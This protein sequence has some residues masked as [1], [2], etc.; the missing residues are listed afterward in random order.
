MSK[1]EIASI[2]ISALAL[3]ASGGVLLYTARTYAAAHRP[4][5]GIIS[6][7]F[8]LVEDP[9]RAIV[10]KVIIKNVGSL[11]GFLKMLENSACLT[12]ATLTYDLDSVPVATKQDRSLLMPGEI[13]ELPGQ[14]NDYGAPVQMADIL[15]G[16]A[17]IRITLRFSYTTVTRFWPARR[18]FNAEIHF[19]TVKGFEPGFHIMSV[20]AN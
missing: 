1:A 11:P 9:P 19:A 15:S 18:Y 17:S 16:N 6:I 3:L 4:Y 5:I 14:Y 8:Q 20:D 7:P 12:T 13:A 10:W 2:I